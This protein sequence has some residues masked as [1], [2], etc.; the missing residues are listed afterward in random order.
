M[1]DPEREQFEAKVGRLE[2]I[3]E[4]QAALIE[5][6]RSRIEELK[7]SLD[8]DSANSSLPPSRDSTDRRARRAAERAETKAT[9]KLLGK[10]ARAPG[11]QKGTPGSTQSPREPD[12]IVVHAPSTCSGCG[13]SLS[14]APV[15]GEATR[16]VLEIPEPRL[17][18]IDHV[19]QRRRCVCGHESRGEFPAEVTGPVSWGPRAKAVGA[20]LIGR[21]HLPLERAGEA[22]AVLFA[23]PMGEGSLAGLLPEAPGALGG[24][25][26]RVR[27][28]LTGCPVVHADETS[29][30]IK[31]GL[32]WVH[33]VASPD[34]TYLALHDKRGIDA[35]VDI[36]VL[37]N[38]TGTIVHD[39][40]ASYDCEELSAATHAQCGA[41]LVRALTTSPTIVPRRPGHRA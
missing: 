6:L 24:F 34:Y 8:K 37:N 26:D 22:M 9:N 35:I 2:A 38:Y 13:A 17:E 25:L 41:H 21:Q 14:D 12:R 15:V 4:A 18:A 39:G 28:L 7:A 32:G 1:F 29:V 40:L 10:A 31:V 30:R 23:A 36:G 33:T 27:T 19:V 16:Q 11:K 20:H 5:E 3:I